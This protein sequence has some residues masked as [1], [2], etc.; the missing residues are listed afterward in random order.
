MGIILNKISELKV[1]KIIHRPTQHFDEIGNRLYNTFEYDLPYKAYYEGSE[2]QRLFAKLID[3]SPY[4]LV[5]YYGF[6]EDIF[7]V[8]L[9]SIFMVI[10]SGS[11]VEAIWGTTFGK[12]IFK[13]KIV[14]DFGENPSILKSLARNSLCLLNFFPEFSDVIYKD[15][16]YG[17]KVVD[18]MNFSMDLNNKICKTYALKEEQ[19]K[20][21]QDLL[22]QNYKE[23][24][25]QYAKVN[26]N[27]DGVNKNDL[28]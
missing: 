8:V 24:D 22:L 18:K 14:D 9:L 6:H 23:N 28:Y 20:E 13:M 1:K 21:V 10:I 7:L 26:P 4:I 27:I 11:I 5:G 12:K 19:V 3:I 25:F 17:T 2:R 15:G 16:G